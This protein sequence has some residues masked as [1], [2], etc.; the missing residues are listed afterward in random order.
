MDLKV[1]TRHAPSNYGSLLQSIATVNLLEGVG[2]KCTII[3]YQRPDERGLKSI[4]T[5]LHDKPEWNGSMLKRLL[6]IALRFPTEQYARNKFDRFRKKYLPMTPRF[7]NSSEL[8]GLKADIFVTGSDQVWGPVGADKIDPAYFLDFTKGKKFALAASFG[9]EKLT[10]ESVESIRSMLLDYDA[11]TVREASASSL[12]KDMGL[13]S[14]RTVIDPTL[15]VTSDFW[16]TLAQGSKIHNEKYLLIYQIHNNPAVDIYASRLAKA[17]GLKLVRISPFAHQ[18][19]RAGS[20]ILLPD[21]KDFI[22]YIDKAEMMVTDSFHGTCF[23][24]SLGTQF[25]TVIPVNGTGTRNRNLLEQLGL[26]DRIVHGTEDDSVTDLKAIDFIRV[27]ERLKK[28]R[29]DSVEYI[30]TALSAFS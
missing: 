5:A 13:E 27:N 11:I 2:H 14:P 21:P 19:T 6:Y 20:L 8:T 30:K 24:V 26:T 23:A 15:M 4:T 3:D 9:R 18:I 16:R 29:E 17:K 22:N 1:I 10:K 12:I 28:L 7:S 25:M